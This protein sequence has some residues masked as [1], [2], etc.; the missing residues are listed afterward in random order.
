M[1]AGRVY[2][3]GGGLAGLSAAVRLAERERAVVLI[4]GADKPAAGAAPIST[5][6]SA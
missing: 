1:S 3:I 5:R 4:E 6:R 2:V